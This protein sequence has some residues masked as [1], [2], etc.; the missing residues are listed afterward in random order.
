MDKFLK[1]R[2]N[3]REGSCT[4][5]ESR[6][7]SKKNVRTDDNGDSKRKKNDEVI[8]EAAQNATNVVQ[9]FSGT[10]IACNNALFR[11]RSESSE[12]C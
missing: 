12:S 11:L 1:K 7:R 3:K 4:A 8:I 2:G 10:F 6:K 5:E 9:F